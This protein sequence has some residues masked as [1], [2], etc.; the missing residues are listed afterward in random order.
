MDASFDRQAAAP[1]TPESFLVGEVLPALFPISHLSSRARFDLF[2]NRSRHHHLLIPTLS[3]PRSPWVDDS[4]DDPSVE[5][6]AN[7]APLDPLNPR[8]IPI[9]R[10]AEIIS[11]FLELTQMPSPPTEAKEKYSA[12]KYCN[13]S[14]TTLESTWCLSDPDKKSHDDWDND[15]TSF[16]SSIDQ[17]VQELTMMSYRFRPARPFPNKGSDEVFPPASIPMHIVVL[18]D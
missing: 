10:N 12:T 16:D 2:C 15:D 17:E 8:W 11:P 18:E 14:F 3:P 7:V 4:E 5:S 1:K 13:Q 9:E 6:F